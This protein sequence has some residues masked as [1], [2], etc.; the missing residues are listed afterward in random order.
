MI[1][2]NLAQ[3]YAEQD[4]WAKAA[5]IYEKVAAI[6]PKEVK[7]VLNTAVKGD[8]VSA[9]N[10][11]LDMMLKHGLS[12]FDVVKQIHSEIWN[13]EIPDEK[14]VVLIDKCAEIEFRMVEG[15]NEFLQLEA[16]LANF[17]L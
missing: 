9:K 15:S 4:K 11:L 10:Q 7:E 16:L 6:R 1:L 14:K 2:T 17:I 5:S 13:L 12:G 8:F 3:L